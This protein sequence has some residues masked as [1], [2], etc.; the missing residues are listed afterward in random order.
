VKSA[1]P[2]IPFDPRLLIPVVLG[3]V[4]AT[5]LWKV[6]TLDFRWF[7]VAVVGI[8]AVSVAMLALG[9][10]GQVGFYVFLFTMQLASLEKWFFKNT[11]QEDWQGTLLYTG[12]IGLGP[13]DLVLMGLLGSWLVRIFVTREEP[14][15]RF[16]RIDI[17]I[18][19]LILAYCFSLPGAPRISTGIFAIVYLLKHV[20]AYFYVSRNLRRHHLPWVIAAAI[21]AICMQSGIGVLQSRFHVLEGL[22]R[23]KGMGSAER[24]AQYEVPGI[25]E[26]VRAEGTLYD[27][28]TYGC[29]LAMMLAFPFMMVQAP[30]TSGRMRA[31]YGAVFVVGCGAL[32]LSYSRSAWVGFGV[33][34][35]WG[36]LLMMM[37]RHPGAR[38]GL[39]IGAISAIAIAPWGAYYLWDRFARAPGEIMSVRFEGYDVAWSIW[40]QHLLFGYGIGN[41]LDGLRRYSF[42]FTAELAVHNVALW[43]GT[44][45][46]I[47]GVTAFYGLI[48]AACIRFWKIA[49]SGG[50]MIRDLAYVPLI[51]LVAYVVDGMAEP[52]FREP[53]VFMTFWFFIALAVGLTR[54][55]REEQFRATP[56][57]VPV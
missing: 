48:V 33:S 1:A 23:D 9:H 47:F 24:Q 42:N 55:Q 50:G 36:F 16:E 46:G 37:T 31:L 45:T 43:L 4:F 49:T 41:Y 22:A 39:L 8:A 14:L 18:L 51:A 54:L 26:K 29:Y 2:R 32:V 44:E 52:T 57:P 21:F 53:V 27:S 5:G 17:W 56:A 13:I 35:V 12:L 11:V 6:W 38:R 7:A 20:L 30:R 10:I 25:E 19:M 3:A 40:K 34:I 28:H 15:P